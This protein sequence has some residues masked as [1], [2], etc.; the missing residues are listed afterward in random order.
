MSVEGE[1]ARRSALKML[2]RRAY[3]ARELVQRL[4]KRG[5]DEETSQACVRALAEAGAVDDRALGES[6]AR[7]ELARIPA[8]RAL[9]EMKLVR[10]GIDRALAGEI[11]REALSAR[12]ADEDAEDVARR[13][14]KSLAPTLGLDAVRRRLYG[15]LARRGFAPDVARGAVERVVDGLNTD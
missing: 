4:V 3:S 14:L 15:K 9:L 2:D 8:G 12:A 5:H 10:R 7:A 1:K 13:H 6:V 11:V